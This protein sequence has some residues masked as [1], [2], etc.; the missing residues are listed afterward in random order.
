MPRKPTKRKQPAAKAP[1][2]TPLE[3]AFSHLLIAGKNH[4]EAAAELGLSPEDAV[5][6]NAKGKIHTYVGQ[7]RAIFMERMAAREVDILIK[8]K[9]TRETIAEKLIALADTPPERTRGSIEGQV[10][11]L[12]SAVALLGFKFDPTKLPWGSMSDEELKTLETGSNTPQ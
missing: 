11:A 7:Y 9:I 3:S 5:R 2:L 6:Y 1:P 10:K 4:L 8:R 12:D